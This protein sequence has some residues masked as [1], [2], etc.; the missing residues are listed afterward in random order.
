MMSADPPPVEPQPVESGTEVS[1]RDKA[2]AL[3]LVLASRTLARSELLRHFLRYV[4]EMALSGRTDQITEH[5]IGVR[6]LGRPESFSPGEDSS[7]RNRARS[8]RLKLEEFY[9]DERPDLEIRI[10]IPVGNYCPSFR[11][12]P[13]S[14]PP[15]PALVANA[16]AASP[17]PAPRISRAVLMAAFAA[18]VLAT[19]AVVWLAPDGT[20]PD[21]LLARF[22][23]PLIRKDADVTVTIASPP[24]LFVRSFPKDAPPKRTLYNMPPELYSWYTSGRQLPDTVELGIQPTHNSPLW[25]DAAAAV[26]T[27]GFLA[28]MGVQ[29][30]IRPE[31]IIAFPA[32]RGRNCVVLGTPEYSPA[33]QKLLERGNFTIAYSREAADYVIMNRKPAGKEPPYYAP[34]R[35]EGRQIVEVYA[36]ITVLPSDGSPGG[37]HRTMVLSGLNSAGTEAAAEYIT[38]PPYLQDLERRL[39]QEGL[40]TSPPAYQVLIKSTTDDTLPLTVSYVTHRVLA[41]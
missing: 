22:W 11:R 6:A 26:M 37:Q 40:N 9:R 8:L 31:R 3:E 1:E 2:A 25:G 21:P 24:Q 38:S 23:G 19:C 34:H 36:L 28:R 14:Q 4:G 33:A 5:L 41:Q 18:G 12:I 10:E 17:L 32:F 35:N 39:R 15:Q 16:S 7:V 20:A 29:V 27:G 30:H 13:S